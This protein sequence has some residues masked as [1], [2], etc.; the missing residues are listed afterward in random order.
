[1]IADFYDSNVSKMEVGLENVALPSG[2]QTITF[3][4]DFNQ[5]LENVVLPSGLLT[6]TFGDRFNQSLENV[7]LPSGLQTITANEDV[8]KA[9]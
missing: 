7:T 2:L 5:S 9:R 4:R 3:G 1:M 8:M 6:I